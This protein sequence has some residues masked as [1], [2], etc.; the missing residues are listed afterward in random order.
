MKKEEKAT[1]VAELTE[2][3][4]RAR[5]AIVT[6]CAGLPVNHVTELRKQLLARFGVAPY[7][8]VIVGRTQLPLT[9]SGKLRRFQTR[10]E[11]LRESFTEIIARLRH[12]PAGAA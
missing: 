4:G 3:F 11:Y 2:K 7:D 8:I 5:L 10:T 6:E 12:A 1:A 9:T